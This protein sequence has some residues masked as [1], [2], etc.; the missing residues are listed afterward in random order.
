MFFVGY[1]VN[2]ARGFFLLACLQCIHFLLFLY[3]FS[4]FYANL[5]LAPFWGA[6]L[7]RHD[8]VVC[9]VSSCVRVD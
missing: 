3:R 2:V 4:S 8:H 1:V 6:F 7:V 9:G 5:W